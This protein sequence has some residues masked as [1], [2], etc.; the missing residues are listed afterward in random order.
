MK[1]VIYFIDR[2]SMWVGHSF[3]WLI[4]VLTFAISYEVFVRKAFRAPTAWAFDISYIMYGAMFMMAGAYTLSR[5]GH[6]RGDVIYRLLKPR[7][8]AWVELVLYFIFFFPGILALIYAGMDYAGESWSYMPYGKQGLR[9]EISIN[10]P[11]GIPVSPLKTLLPISAAV[12]FLQGIAEVLRCILCIQ[13]GEWQARLQD[14]EE[15][16]TVLLQKAQERQA[17]EAAAQGGETEGGPP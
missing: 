1:R 2:F 15:T 16:E 8:Q 9:G 5:D 14:V 4:L 12:L 3:A 7:A 10:S 11:A 13:S 6:V 17:A